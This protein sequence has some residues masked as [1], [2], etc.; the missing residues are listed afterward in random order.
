MARPASP[1]TRDR[2]LDSAQ[3]L[4][5][6]RGFNAFS[7]ADISKELGI[8]KA[9]IH[10]HF[11]TKAGLAKGL[12]ERYRKAFLGC[13]S[14]IDQKA[15]EAPEKLERYVALYLRV[16]K[17][18]GR[19]CLCGMMA[20]DFRTLSPSVRR[21]VQE[22]FDANEGWL[23]RV[24][25][26]GRKAGELSFSGPAAQEARVLVSALEGAMLVSRSYGDPHR[27]VETARRVLETLAVRVSR[28]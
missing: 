8:R 25:E 4:V 2:I 10:H 7:Y 26:E 19:M 3:R 13:L 12:I 1:G 11:P 20:A 16:L 9:S 14:G 18:E 22:F 27:F 21:A 24:L 15:R 6:T 28:P 23:S 5:Q 17:D